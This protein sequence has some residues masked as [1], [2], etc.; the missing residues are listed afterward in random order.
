MFQ[1]VEF[2]LLTRQLF[3][4]TNWINCE[5]MYAHQLMKGKNKEKYK[6][7]IEMKVKKPNTK[8]LLFRLNLFHSFVLYTE[9]NTQQDEENEN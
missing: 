7:N 2:E 5:R 6:E 3:H 8:I 4:V 9:H 1:Y